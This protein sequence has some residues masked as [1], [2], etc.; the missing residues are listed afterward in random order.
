MTTSSGGSLYWSVSVGVIV[1]RFQSR[2]HYNAPFRVSWCQLHQ[3]RCQSVSPD[4]IPHQCR[5]R[6]VCMLVSSHTSVG[7]SPYHN[8]HTVSSRTSPCVSRCQ[9]VSHGVS[10]YLTVSSG[11]SPCVS[12]CQAVSHGVSSCFTV[13][14]GTSPCV[15]PCELVSSHSNLVVSR[16]HTV[17]SRTSPCVSRCQA[18]SAG[19]VPVRSSVSRSARSMQ[20]RRE[21]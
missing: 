1:T 7:V 16:Y 8:C 12:R 9:A 11:T 3:P 21:S 5:C 17:S 18:V 4:V 6:S 10:S 14:S 15:S 20:H 2:Y 13:S 19:I